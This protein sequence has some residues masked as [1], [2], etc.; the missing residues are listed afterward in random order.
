[1]VVT[2][3]AQGTGHAR[4]VDLVADTGACR[5]LDRQT[6]TSTAG[7]PGDEAWAATSS[8][9]APA[10]RAAVRLRDLV[11]SVEV[12]DPKGTAAAVAQAERLVGLLAAKLHAV[13]LLA[14]SGG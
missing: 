13:G 14:A 5:F 3:W 12:S 11:V 4:F 9:L 7:M 8:G 10:G 2:G 6:E 1:V